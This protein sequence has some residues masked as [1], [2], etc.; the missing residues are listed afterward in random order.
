MEPDFDPPPLDLEEAGRFY[1][2]KAIDARE[3]EAAQ[4]QEATI[5]GHQVLVS[6]MPNNLLSD[7]MIDAILQQSGMSDDAIK[8]FKASPG[9]H[10]SG[11][12]ADG[13]LLITL[14][15]ADW[16]Q[17]CACHFHGRAWGSAVVSAEVLPMWESEPEPV[18]PLPAWN[19]PAQASEFVPYITQPRNSQH[20][21]PEAIRVEAASAKSWL[22]NATSSMLK[23]K[24]GSRSDA[25]TRDE[26]SESGSGD[27]VS[28]L[29]S[30]E[31]LSP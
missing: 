8:G 10:V 18:V 26:E 17:W 9:K 15:S 5:S 6:G 29:G 21:I 2:R 23:E 30:V 12:K 11:P 20:H 16:A 1:N 14:S 3:W 27:E 13:Q 28:K 25:S 4:S 24:S 19:W 22:E 7:M 31:V